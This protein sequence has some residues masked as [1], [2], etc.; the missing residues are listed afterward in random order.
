ML[1]REPDRPWIVAGS[2]GG[3]AQPQV[4]A[5]LV[6]ALV[7]GGLDVRAAVS[8]PR[9]YVGA[10]RH[11]A[12]PIDLHIE[13]RFEP[14]VLESLASMGHDVQPG[15]AFDSGLGHEHAIELVQG[16]PSTDGGSVAA[17][18]DPRSAGLP[19]VW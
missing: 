16:G 5:Q 7:D 10:E 11:F 15:E 4:H 18:T 2:M 13:P 8:A 3:D 19:A 17:A 14:G 1:F 6:S 9:W 12:P